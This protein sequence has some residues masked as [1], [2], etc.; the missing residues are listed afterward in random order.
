MHFLLAFLL[1]LAD[2]QEDSADAAMRLAASWEQGASAVD[3]LRW[4]WA[5]LRVQRAK[6]DAKM[7]RTRS[8][9]GKNSLAAKLV[10]I[11]AALDELD[12]RL[13]EKELESART[14]DAIG[15][16]KSAGAVAWYAT[17]GLKKAQEPLLRAAMAMAVA[18]SKEAGP[19]TLVAALGAS[20]KPELVVPLLQALG[21]HA[22][23]E[24]AVPVL[25]KFLENR[26]WTVRVAAAFALARTARPEGVEPV[27]LALR[28]ADP[29]S[30]EQRE[31]AAAL[32]R[33]TGQN[34]G[35]FPD[36]WWKWWEAE[37]LNVLAGRVPLGKG[38]RH[39]RSTGEQ[40]TFYGI[41]QEEERIIY[42]VDISGSMA[43]SMA[44]PRWIDGEAVPARDD[45][46][47][48]YDAALRELLRAIRKLRPR[49]TFGVVLYSSRDRPLTDAML[50][51]TPENR[52]RIEKELAYTGPAGSTNIYAALDRAL[53]M[54]GVHPHMTGGKQVADAIYLL[55]D[56]APTDAKGKTE[57]PERTLVAVREWNALGKIAI[58]TVGI[59]HQHSRGF[60]EALAEQNGGRYY[61]VGAK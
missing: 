24:Q 32:T 21:S 44:N 55:S 53:R 1:L 26:D 58:H 35:A 7:E 40:G 2:V 28:S 45:E 13:S 46:D 41:P 25:A 33:Y 10:E 37:K 15:A 27:L 50:P 38:A 34:H 16:L 19:D 17:S 57:D 29:K 56:G 48:R 4:E 22:A 51:A 9:S 54:A 52:A 59:G 47:S 36:I 12:A 11:D 23:S 18:R 6:T 61:A 49:T 31:L 43:V 14:L 5:K 20:R 30:R 42:V 8:A 3:K 60:L 39:A